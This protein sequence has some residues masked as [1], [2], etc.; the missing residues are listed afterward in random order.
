ME[1]YVK[2]TERVGAPYWYVDQKK[3][4]VRQ[5]GFPEH[6]Y[7]AEFNDVYCDTLNI[8]D[9]TITI[10][11]EDIRDIM[12]PVGSIYISVNNINP[13][14]FFGGTWEAFATGKTLIGVD[15]NDTDFD[16]VEKT[17]GNKNLPDLM[18]IG[19]NYGGT[20]TSGSPS[21][22]GRLYTSSSGT[23]NTSSG[24]ASCDRSV[25]QPYICVYMWKRTA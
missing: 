9:N 6:E 7:S 13:Q 15:T 18:Q 8:K 20:T 2:S 17:G 16:S 11:N 4:S 21:Y 22:K 14:T 24:A 5:N 23:A 12:Y 10:N 3:H 25:V 1:Q 19:T